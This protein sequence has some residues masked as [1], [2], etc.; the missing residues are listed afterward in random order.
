[1]REDTR[2]ARYLHSIDPAAAF[3]GVA[4]QMR[5]LSAVLVVRRRKPPYFVCG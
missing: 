2:T 5:S 4:D 3:A 1:M